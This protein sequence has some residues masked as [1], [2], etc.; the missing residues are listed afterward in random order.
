MRVHM[1]M[2]RGYY[3]AVRLIE[4]MRRKAMGVVLRGQLRGGLS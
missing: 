4:M 1:Q 2:L 3:A